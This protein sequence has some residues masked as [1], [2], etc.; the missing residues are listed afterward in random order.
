MQDCKFRRCR[1]GARLQV[2]YVV[3][4]GTRLQVE[5]VVVVSARLQVEDVVLVPND[6]DVSI[7]IYI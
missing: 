6:P 2:E 5:D 3:V 1:F 7:N 4:V